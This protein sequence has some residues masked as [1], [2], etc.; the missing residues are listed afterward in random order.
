MLIDTKNSKFAHTS[1][2]PQG[3]LRWTRGFWLDRFNTCADVTIP[4]VFSVFDDKNSF[5][6]QVENFRIAAGLSD[7]EFR[8]T[9]YGDG[10]FY[11]L[12][13][14]MAYTYSFRKDET[15]NEKMDEYIALVAAA[16]Q[17]DGYISTKQIIGE[18]LS[19]GVVR[20]G[21]I[22]DFEEYNFGHLFTAACIHKRSTGKDN[23][24][25]IA[26]H[27]AEYL[28]NM[29]TAILNGEKAHTAVCPSHYMG[30]FEM[31]RTTGDKKYLDM[32]KTAIKMRDLVENGTDDNQDRTPLLEQR[33]IV[34]HAVRSTYLYAGVADLYLETGDPELLPVLNS[35]WQDLMD[36]KLYITGGCGALYTG[37]SPFGLL[38]DAKYVH[39]A[40]GYAYQLPNVTAYNET[41]GTLGHIFW[42]NRM[43][44][45]EQ[46]AEY[47]DLIE[48]SHYNLVLAAISLDGNKYFYENMLR[49]TKALD[50][51]VMWPVERSDTFSCFCCPTNLAR[52]IP[53]AVDYAY[54][55]SDD[56][57]WCGMYGA[58]EANISLKNGANFTLVQETN[59]P[60]SANI[61]LKVTNA[62]SDIGFN[63]KARVPS[64]ISSGT[65]TYGDIAR[66]LTSA[67]ANTF[68]NIEIKQPN[69]AVVDIVFDMPARYVEANSMVEEDVNQVCVLRG[70]LVY[71]AESMD[72]DANTLDD[73]ML[74]SNARFTEEWYQIKDTKVIALNTNAAQII[75][76]PQS[77]AKNK[78]LYRDLNV[79]GLK[80]ASL[81][82]IPYFAWDNR[83]FGEMR[84]WMPIHFQL[85]V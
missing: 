44:A 77:E 28:D 15:L 9:P 8:G 79:T 49:R 53:Q 55:I 51:P 81:R 78:K 1:S 30:L 65:L 12:M 4:H 80:Q 62:S 38:L 72:A 47:L 27:C 19:N 11:K 83:G 69:N 63:L 37:T 24:M 74:L 22:D 60:W 56:A 31:Y 43:F 45:L 76:S 18:K 71:C 2:L 67:D 48:R 50:Y 34:G 64:W 3:N 68:I 14:G 16:Q 42:A 41:C 82:L 5:F 85:N 7:G 52:S 70:P 54:K 35:C 10:D 58:S 66:T 61:R 73:I 57:V 36:K 84:I 75:R 46:K 23:F 59:Y 39:Q 26:K 20:H 25:T 6:H 32:G 29:Y 40:F 17:P 13:E 21:D 33:T